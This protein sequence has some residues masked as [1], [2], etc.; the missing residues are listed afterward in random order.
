MHVKLIAHTVPVKDFPGEQSAEAIIAYCARVSSDNQ[1]NPEYEKLFK[2]CLDNGHVSILETASLTLEIETSRAISAQILRHRSFCFQEF[3]AR[4]QSVT[5]YEGGKARRQDKKN[6]QSSHEDLP[7]KTVEWFD[8]VQQAVWIYT[9]TLY[10]EAMKKG[11]AKECARMILP[12]G[13]STTL[14]MTGSARS[15]IHFIQ[16]RTHE[17]T[18]KEHRDIALEAKKIFSEVFPTVAKSLGW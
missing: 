6:R 12:I 16:T 17:S 3:S 2:Y 8:E 4:F 5:K 9:N 15:W 7:Q 13:V 14:Y 11:I 18:Q 1:E 10:Q